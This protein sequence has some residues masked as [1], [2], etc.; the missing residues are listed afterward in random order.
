MKKIFSILLLSAVALTAFAQTDEYQV[1]YKTKQ[2]NAF[3]NLGIGVEAGLM[4]A[5]VQLA[6]PVVSNH[7]V[8][9]VGYNFM[10][11]ISYN[12]D[13][14][15][16]TGDLNNQIDKL[17]ADVTLYNTMMGKNYTTVSRVNNNEVIADISAKLKMNNIK[18]LLEYYPSANRSFHFTAGVM[19]GNEDLISLHG[20]PDAAAQKSYLSAMKLHS[21]MQADGINNMN[22]D[23]KNSV[24]FNIDDKTYT[25]DD[26]GNVDATIEIQ[27]IKPYL[28]IGFGR[29]VPNKRVGFQFE[30][31]AWMH[32]TPTI[33]GPEAKVY[34]PDKDG[35]EGVGDVM[36]KITFYPQ[37]TFRLTGR[38]F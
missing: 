36:S 20:S 4:G 14:T 19:I 23:V 17:N 27:K 35:V 28:G 12:T 3:R 34:N 7:L 13:L 2:M 9:V 5:G 11:E 33:N 18:A 24:A 29:A 38:I 21:Q 31:G 10:P 1:E 16:S 15:F 8:L 32:G 6:M 22:I 25:L 30:L 26:N 37:M